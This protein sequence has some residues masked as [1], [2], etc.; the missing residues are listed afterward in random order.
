MTKKDYYETLGISKDA[1]VDDIKRA[2]KKMAVQH[3]PDKNPDNDK[4]ADM[5]K[6]IN[7]AYSVLSDPDKKHMYDRF[8]TVEGMPGGGGGMP[9]DMGDILKNMFGGGMPGGGMP[10]GF[11][12]MFSEGGGPEDMFAHIFGGGGRQR[13]PAADMV[14]V[15]VDI[16]DIYYGNTKRVEFE[17]LEQCGECKGTGA[18]DP[19]N[20]I[21]CITCGGEGGVMHQM[22]PFFAQR[23]ICQ[24]CGGTGST[25]KNGKVCGKC[26]GKKHIYNKKSFDLKLPKGVPHNHEVK[27]E[28][29][30]G[31]DER[32]KQNKDIVFRFKYEIAEPYQ[33]DQFMNVVYTMP[34]N[35]EELM[36]G[37]TKQ[38]KLYKDDVTLV[39]ERYFNPNKHIVVKGRGI[40]NMR[41]NRSTDLVIK[42]KVEFTDS[43]RLSK[44]NDVIQKVLKRDNV[45]TETSGEVIHVKLG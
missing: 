34:I 5:F 8:G 43:E 9:G 25:I 22:G 2:F 33:L 37:F 3:H 23:V 20:I 29:K 6:T 16:N 28:K 11:S 36:G 41:K 35:I 38:I 13:G 40:W 42:F 32:S 26:H 7:E 27:M 21:K 12:F 4:A 45:A 31:W 18:Q 39:S 15:K 14:E 19:S 24:S 30:G 1:S 10:G 44:Y 17:L